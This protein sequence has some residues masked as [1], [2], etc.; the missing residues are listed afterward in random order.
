M[1][2]RWVRYTMP[3]MVQVDS[4]DEVARVVTLPE[5]IRED[6]DDRGDFCVYDADF[7]RRDSDSPA[8][9]HAQQAARP[10]WEY[11]H[12]RAGPPKNWPEP[13]E[14]EEGFDL[15]EADDRYADF[16]VYG[17]SYAEGKTPHPDDR[18]EW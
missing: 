11:D 15:T 18:F 8:S 13:V 17:R 1:A 6:R 2:A 14:W 5:E 4:D 16:C 10:E 3:I 7:I 12:L 9:I